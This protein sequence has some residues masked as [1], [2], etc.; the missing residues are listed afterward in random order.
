VKRTDSLTILVPLLD[1]IFAFFGSPFSFLLF[2]P[3]GM[4]L[5]FF[6]GG[7]FT[8]GAEV[9]LHKFMPLTGC[10]KFK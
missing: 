10:I 7:G 6:Y 8:L 3:G 1:I 5:G 4:P 9:T 2:F